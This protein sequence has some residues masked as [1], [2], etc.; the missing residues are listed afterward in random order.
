[1]KVEQPQDQQITPEL[2][3]SA[4]AAGWFPMAGPTGRIEWHSPDPRCI[5]TYESFRVSRSLRK[6][7]ERGGFEVRFDTAFPT[8]MKQC[9]LRPEGTWISARIL[10]LY[11]ELARL[12]VAH[13]VEA[14]RAGR[15]AGGLYGVTLGAAFFG[16]SMFHRTTDASKVALVA[17]M[18]CCQAGGFTLIDSQWIT[19]HLASLGA[20]E[21]PRQEYLARLRKAIETP[22]RFR[23]G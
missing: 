9:A 6:A 5:F 16:E 18:R 12:G 2:V 10:E 14:W 1:M 15:L 7:V 21:I 13:S 20:I 8:V 3:L 23:S 22:A 4:Y 19:P 17:L 11:G